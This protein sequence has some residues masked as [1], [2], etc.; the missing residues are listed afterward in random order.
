[1]F[2]IPELLLARAEDSGERAFCSFRGQRTTFRQLLHGVQDMAA[3]LASAGV[4]PGDRVG[5]MLGSSVEHIQ[6]YLAASWIGATAVPFSIH[7]KAAGIELQLNSCKP[8]VFIANRMHADSIRQ[9]LAVIRH[10]PR[11][12]WLEDGIDRDGEVGLNVLLR[13][14][15]SMRVAAPRSLDDPV[16]LNYTSGT[17]GAPKGVVLSER[18][19]WVG[20]KNAAILSDA[21]RD[22]TFFLWEPFYHIAAWMTV[23][24][25]LHKGLGIYMVERFSASRLW[26]QIAEARATKLHYLGGLVNIILSQP[27][28]ES[29]RNNPVSIAWGA[30]CPADNWRRFEE[31]FEFQVREGYGISEGQNFTH[32]N[33]RGV[34]GSIGTPVE[35]FDS[36]LIDSQG[37][38]VGPGAVGEI[39]LKPKLAGVAMSGYF[40]EPEK[41]AEVIRPDGCVYTGDTATVDQE[42]NYFF[43]G[44]K[45]DALRRR[46]ENVSAWEVER[47]LN[48]APGVEESAV[49][50]VDSPLGDQDILAVVKL[51]EG[52]EQNPLAIAKFC[53]ERLAHY[54]VPRFIQFVDEFPRGPTQRIKKSEIDVD[55]DNAWDT[56]QA[57]YMPARTV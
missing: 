38:R 28:S 30:A 47:V 8:Q 32:L 21:Q 31:R 46:G 55:L 18:W 56:E 48:A 5:F 7:L 22:D 19:Y 12:V 39:V 14:S 9:V 11:L 20:A 40:G 57:G 26:D 33:L 17:T 2:T 41:T 1:M 27:P 50:G 16:A 10:R 53:G 43:K 6:L 13:T 37:K 15:G 44:R 52:S 35:E 3:A 54:Q 36:W 42:G 34:V 4:R 45:K 51:R 23:M 49:V 25:A 24:M 29:E